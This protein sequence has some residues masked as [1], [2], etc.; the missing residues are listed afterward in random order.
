MDVLP[1]P[2]PLTPALRAA[3][4][5]LTSAVADGVQATL[6]CFRMPAKAAHQV[7]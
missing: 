3:V 2:G 6:G 4:S 7:F 5:G 1:D